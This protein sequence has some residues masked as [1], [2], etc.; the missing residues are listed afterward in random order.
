MTDRQQQII[1]HLRGRYADWMKAIR[2]RDLEAILGIYAD[3]AT[4]MPPGR[5]KAQGKE[6]LRAV[7][8]G[9]LQRRDFVAE[10]A[11]TLTVAHGGDMAYDIGHYRITMVLDSGPVEYVGKYVVVWQLLDGRWQAVVD[12]DN[13][14]G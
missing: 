9:Y 11:P 10:Y 7:W 3:H 1:D 14:N 4:Y 6:A 2:E 8:G 12:I 5:P 13:S